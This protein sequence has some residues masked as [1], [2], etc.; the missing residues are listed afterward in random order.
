MIEGAPGDNGGVGAAWVFSRSG[1]VWTQQAKIVP[2][3]AADKPPAFGTSVALSA[4]GNTALIGGP[5][6]N[7]TLPPCLGSGWVFTRS[8]STWSEQEK[9][10]FNFQAV[11]NTACR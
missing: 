7:C 11:A 1:G 10:P 6:D 4:D 2:S 9:I 3:D 5:N 8:G